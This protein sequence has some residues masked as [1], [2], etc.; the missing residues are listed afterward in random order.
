[1]A[2][3]LAER[4]DEL[5]TQ[6]LAPLVLGGRI[7]PVRPLGPRLGLAIGEGR[8]ISDS[9]LRS[10]LD[11]ARVRVARLL[12]PVD[13]VDEVTPED[14]ALVAAL[15][16]L[17]QASNLEL[18]GAFSRSR[19]AKLLDCAMVL[20][21]SVSRP[22]TIAEALARHTLFARAL[23]V[24]RT[25][26]TVSWWTGSASF[27]GQPAPTRLTRWRE[28]R[29]VREDTRRIPLVDMGTD[30]PH[31]TSD[32]WLD[33]LN[34]WLARSPLT[35]L[36]TLAR[37]SPAFRWSEPS[38]SLI[39]TVPGRSL[40]FRAL[41]RQRSADVHTA[42]DRAAASLQAE[43]RPAEPLVKAFAQEVGTGLAMF[44][45]KTAA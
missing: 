23:E 33:A 20:A 16:D 35:D 12:A 14:V 26:T 22:R 15:N 21:S 7:E 25:D 32:M 45:K 19:H 43:L 42:L 44:S 29:R 5:V 31:V 24:I 34:V 4:F 13:T 11:V 3:D 36:A 10:Q 39:A 17:L 40:A 9:E 2:D 27:R 6:V 28:L 38:L 8:K 18:S 30:V 37:R 1:M 41:S